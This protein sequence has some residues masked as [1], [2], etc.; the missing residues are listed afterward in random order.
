MKNYMIMSI[1]R[2]NLKTQTL[3]HV[4]NVRKLE[5]ETS[6]MWANIYIIYANIT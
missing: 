2:K 4:N 1:N 3:F 5:I 6:L